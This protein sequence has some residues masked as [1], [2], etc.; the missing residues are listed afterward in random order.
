[1]KAKASVVAQKL[2][3][4]YRQAHVIEGGWPVLNQIFVNESSDEILKELQ[5]LPTGKLLA[6]HIKNLK[7][8]ETPMDSIAR[9]LLP[10]GGAFA[11]KA[12]HAQIAESDM[13]EL[14]A[15]INAFTPTQQGLE[16]FIATPVIQSFGQEWMLA[17]QS[18]LAND[19][20]MLDKFSQIVRMWNAYKIWMDAKEII[21]QPINDRTRA[22]LQVDMPE[23]ET[24]LP[25]FGEEGAKLLRRLHTLTSSLP[26][27]D[28]TNN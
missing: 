22:Q 6:E 27:S 7:S 28:S 3:N 2:L 8:G 26:S 18:V 5:D 9:E 4:L 21:N 17:I 25:M 20:D 16:T 10:Y 12:P 24:Y 14:I 23:F 13:Q 19:T 11:E 15:A 1:M